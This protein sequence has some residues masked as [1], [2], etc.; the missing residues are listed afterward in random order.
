M[1]IEAY[2]NP[3]FTLPDKLNFLLVTLI[4]VILCIL[5]ILGGVRLS[6]LG[7]KKKARRRAI[8]ERSHNRVQRFYEMIIS[9][10]S[11]MSFSCAYV[12]INHIDN[13][14]AVVVAIKM[15]LPQHV[16]SIR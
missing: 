3:D 14:P 4:G 8:Y 1:S 16:L 11:V 15:R 5:V 2:I 6:T 10:T 13:T 9:A 7:M 12:I